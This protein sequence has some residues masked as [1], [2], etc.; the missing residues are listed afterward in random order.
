MTLAAVALWLVL[1][2]AFSICEAINDMHIRSTYL[3][4]ILCF[5]DSL[6]LFRSKKLCETVFL[7]IVA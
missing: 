4:F 7:M 2:I 6:H 5:Y 3:L 1:E